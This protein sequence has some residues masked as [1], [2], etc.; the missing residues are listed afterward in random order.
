ML[1]P[2]LKEELETL[3][4]I[5]STK[6]VADALSICP[7]TVYRMIYDNQLA[8]FKDD[9]GEWNILK[10]DLIKMCSRNSNQ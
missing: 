5:M 4:T 1:S 9:Y 2:E 3:P 8:A 10:E 7:H 6:D